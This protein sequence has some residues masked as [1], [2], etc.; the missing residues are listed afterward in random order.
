MSSD[1]WAGMV[2][3]MSSFVGVV[4]FG[5]STASAEGAGWSSAESLSAGR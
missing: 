3:L 1:Y 2:N 5:L 4:L